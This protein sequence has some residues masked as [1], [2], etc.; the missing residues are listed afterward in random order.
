[1]SESMWAP[2]PKPYRRMIGSG[3]PA[4]LR[5]WTI[6]PG[7]L[8]TYV[9]RWPR[10]SASSRTP[11]RDILSKGRPSARAKDAV[12]EVLPV[13]G[14]PTNLIETLSQQ[15]MAFDTNGLQKDRSLDTVYRWCVIHPENQSLLIFGVCGEFLQPHDREVLDEPLLDLIQA[16]VIS[17]KLLSGFGQELAVLEHPE[18][19]QMR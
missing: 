16:V 17:V 2:K 10:I 14:G 9:R 13:P 18:R 11:P 3:R 8:A 4:F 5:A 6:E 19:R 15:D 7:P 1:M 12:M